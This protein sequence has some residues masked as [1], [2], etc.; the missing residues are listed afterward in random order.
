[1]AGPWD[2]ALPVRLEGRA[3]G[4]ISV[5]L[6]RGRALDD[7]DL[8]LL[9]A[10]AQQAAM[11]FRNTVLA[12]QLAAHVDELE[13][14]TRQLAESR[15]RLVEADDA[16]RRGLEETIARQVLPLIADLPARIGGVR[17]AI[18][19]G[20]T[21]P[22]IDPLVADTNT[23]LESLRDLS[24]G[25]F[26]AQLARVGL[27][28]TLRS[29]LARTDGTARL[30]RRRRSTVGGSRR[31]WRRRSTSAASRPSAGA[32]ASPSLHLELRDRDV[33]LRIDGRRPERP[34]PADGHRPARCRRRASHL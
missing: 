20:A 12:S 8:R 17:A 13:R 1:M 2:H 4:S 5:A 24:R 9:E 14:T 29:M 27:V 15:L 30:E 21:D 32:S 19:A 31:G 26:P 6:A 11:A 18:A 7:A 28:P 3:L 25:V 33:R 10:V 23:A 34:R 22:G 16:A